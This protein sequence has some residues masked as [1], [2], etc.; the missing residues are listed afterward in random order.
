MRRFMIL[1]AML[2]SLVTVAFLM[3]TVFKSR[4]DDTGSLTP[5]PGILQISA[6]SAA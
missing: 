1:L 2:A 6:Y 5:R 4:G 3:N